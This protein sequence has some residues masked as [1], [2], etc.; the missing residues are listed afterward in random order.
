M[1]P[2]STLP[3]CT[4]TSCWRP[5]LGCRIIAHRLQNQMP[6]EKG[7]QQ[8]ARRTDYCMW[9]VHRRPDKLQIHIRK[10]AKNIPVLGG[11][12][13]DPSTLHARQ[14]CSLNF[15]HCAFFTSETLKYFHE[16]PLPRQL[17]LPHRI[18]RHVAESSPSTMTVARQDISLDLGITE[19]LP[20]SSMLTTAHVCH[21][22]T[23]TTRNLILQNIPE[24][25]THMLTFWAPNRR[26]LRGHILLHIPKQWNVFA[27]EGRHKIQKAPHSDLETLYPTFPF[28]FPLS[29]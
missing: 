26:P 12:C 7:L 16:T 1:R 29:Q 25:N 20:Q 4:S 3:P 11:F 5:S 23:S 27:H 9:S 6:R 19:F 17:D 15:W 22:N 18:S 2:C 24:V 21:G 10:L 14:R 8:G 28:H 13:A